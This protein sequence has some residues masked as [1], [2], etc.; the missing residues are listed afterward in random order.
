MIVLFREI[1]AVVMWHLNPVRDPDGQAPTK[2]SQ[3][4]VYLAKWTRIA[5][6]IGDLD[7][8]KISVA[9]LND[10]YRLE[11][12]AFDVP[13]PRFRVFRQQFQVLFSR[14]LVFLEFGI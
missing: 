12:P 4:P 8:S 6:V 13:V 2:V 11:R 3:R 14:A 1:L 10:S 9:S 7:Q 5:A